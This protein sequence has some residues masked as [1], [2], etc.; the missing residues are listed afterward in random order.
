MTSSQRLIGPH[1][2]QRM[3]PLAV[4]R[5]GRVRGLHS[6]EHI[7]AASRTLRD[8]LQ[9]TY[10]RLAAASSAAW[11]F[12]DSRALRFTLTVEQCLTA[13]SQGHAQL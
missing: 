3:S 10:A 7:S 5:R 11:P 12:S 1:K 6:T 13:C 4:L 2:W 9:G 8:N